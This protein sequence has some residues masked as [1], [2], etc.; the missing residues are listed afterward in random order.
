MSSAPPTE[1]FSF[2]YQISLTFDRSAQVSNHTF[3]Y[4]PSSLLMFFSPQQKLQASML[5]ITAL[6]FGPLTSAEF[7]LKLSTRLGGGNL[8]V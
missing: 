7:R 8:L 3:V 2:A 6:E 4:C 5:R 1:Q